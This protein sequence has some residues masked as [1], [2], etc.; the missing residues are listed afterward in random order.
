MSHSPGG[1]RFELA[2]DAAAVAAAAMMAGSGLCRWEIIHLGDYNR[3]NCNNYLFKIYIILVS[4]LITV[5]KVLEW[6]VSSYRFVS[7]DNIQLT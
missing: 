5:R 6:I 2:A 4:T 1:G 7:I 3:D